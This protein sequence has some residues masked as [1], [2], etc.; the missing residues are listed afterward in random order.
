M[1]INKK[2]VFILCLTETQKSFVSR[3]IN[4]NRVWGGG[5]GGNHFVKKFKFM[6]IEKVKRAGFWC[7]SALLMH[8]SGSRPSKNIIRLRLV[9]EFR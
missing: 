9:N 3:K 6:L 4:V 5:G 7:C 1:K 8:F 2:T